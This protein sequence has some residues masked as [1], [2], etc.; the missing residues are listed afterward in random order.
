MD[1]LKSKR[2]RTFATIMSLRLAKGGLTS[3]IMKSSIDI[4]IGWLE[5]YAVLLST[6]IDPN[7]TRGNVV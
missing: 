4:R 2:L 6:P 7:K 1:K 5:E 3:P